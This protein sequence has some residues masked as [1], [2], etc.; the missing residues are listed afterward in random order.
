V[1]L[2]I[3]ALVLP[4]ALTFLVIV[5]AVAAH[6]V[7]L[8]ISHRDYLLQRVEPDFPVLGQ[9]VNR[10]LPFRAH[11]ICPGV[12]SAPDRVQALFAHAVAAE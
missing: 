4:A 8:Q 7:S 1:T 2:D 5:R 11:F 12:F 10:P 9:R 6:F 3:D